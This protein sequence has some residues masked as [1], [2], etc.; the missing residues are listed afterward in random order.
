[1]SATDW[2]NTCATYIRENNQYVDMHK[3]LQISEKKLDEYE[4][5]QRILATNSP[6][7]K[8]MNN[9]HMK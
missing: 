8:P 4:N 5:T 2:E 1:M 7:R 3:E 6:R 9:K